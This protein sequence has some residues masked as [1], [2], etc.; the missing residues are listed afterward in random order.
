MIYPAGDD[1]IQYSQ[2]NFVR[3]GS[4]VFHSPLQSRFWGTHDT[5]WQ[6]PLVLLFAA[7]AEN[8]GHEDLELS[9]SRG[10]IVNGT[11]GIHK[12]LIYLTIFTNSIWSY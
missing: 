2:V 7:A 5:T 8:T 10:T 12:N 4:L 3:S 1:L 6:W 11:Y 9:I